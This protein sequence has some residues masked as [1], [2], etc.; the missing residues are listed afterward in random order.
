MTTD[1][2][3]ITGRILGIPD[4][5]IEAFANGRGGRQSAGYVDLGNRPEDESRALCAEV[6]TA[7]GRQ[8][9]RGGW[10][11]TDIRRVYIPCP[12]HDTPD[13]PGWIGHDNDV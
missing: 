3:R 13:T 1:E 10:N 11:N 4:C 2:H 9:P 7:L 6:S 8:W 12:E 5:C